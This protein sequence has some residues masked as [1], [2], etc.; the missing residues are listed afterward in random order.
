[1]REVLNV[2]GSNPLR[3]ALAEYGDVIIEMLSAPDCNGIADIVTS[4]QEREL[5]DVT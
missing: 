5:E 1:M 4:I 2:Y 3:S